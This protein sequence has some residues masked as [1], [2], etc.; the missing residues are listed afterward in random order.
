M[1]LLP[2]RNCGQLG[3]ELSINDG[4]GTR[5]TRNFLDGLINIIVKR[6]T[7]YFDVTGENIFLRKEKQILSVICPSIADMTCDFVMEQPLKR[8]P[9]GEEESTG[10]VDY[11]INY[12]NY[13]YLLELKHTDF[14]YK[15]ADNPP[16]YI[17]KQFNSALIQ[18]KNIRTDQCKYLTNDKGI[19]KVAIQTVAFYQHSKDKFED[20][21]VVGS[22]MKLIKKSPFDEKPNLISL[23]LVPKKLKKHIEYNNRDQKYIYP[24]IA[25]V[26]YVSDMK[27]SC[28]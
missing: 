6:A 26:G 4:D 15:N 17:S 16:E 12:H 25:F 22:F 11:W 1:K 9:T 28:N 24:A 2:V 10:R 7:N 20:K 8:K 27:P 18:L 21:D 5:V 13:S 3:I 14:F 23:W 19:F